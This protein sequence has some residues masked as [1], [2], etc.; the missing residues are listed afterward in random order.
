MG[1]AVD[2]NPEP[3]ADAGEQIAVDV[4]R[5]GPS[6]VLAPPSS[7]LASRTTD[8]LASLAPAS[9]TGRVD[10]SVAYLVIAV[11]LPTAAGYLV[12]GAGRLQARREVRRP[13]APTTQS[14]EHL[15]DDLRRLH[16][17]LDVTEN[18]SGLRA[19]N[20][21]CQATRA[22]YVDVLTAACRQLHVTPPAGRPATRAEIYRVEAELRELGLD[23]RRVA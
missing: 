15:R 12:V 6:A 7:R 2:V 9:E 8:L 18:A 19:K 5:R 23:V 17:L 11:L 4:K 20:L 10:G 16:D 14:I 13:A 3:H 1:G 22:A 21:R